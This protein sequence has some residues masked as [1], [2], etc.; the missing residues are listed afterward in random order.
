MDESRIDDILG[1]WVKRP[2]IRNGYDQVEI[3]KVWK[4][5]MSPSIVAYT[6]SIKFSKGKLYL[7]LNS[8]PLKHELSLEKEKLM[9]LL[10]TKIGQNRIKEIY[11][12]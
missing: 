2:R 11:I 3:D 6:S 5:V 1:S 4:E 12:Q 9:K 7:K 8:A 10:N